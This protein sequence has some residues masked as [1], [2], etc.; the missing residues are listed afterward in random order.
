MYNEINLMR[1]PDKHR[2]SGK[3]ALRQL[4]YRM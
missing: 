1:D 2:G 4:E 3:Y